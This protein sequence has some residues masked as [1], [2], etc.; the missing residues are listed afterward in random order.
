M[1]GNQQQKIEKLEQ[2]GL[3]ETVDTIFKDGKIVAAA[4]DTNPDTIILRYNSEGILETGESDFMYR[5]EKPY[6]G[7]ELEEYQDVNE[8]GFL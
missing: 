3:A 2:K 6:E 4:F 7:W 8:G 5:V 1:K